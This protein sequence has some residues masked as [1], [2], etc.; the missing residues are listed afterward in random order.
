MIRSCSKGDSSQFELWAEW[1]TVLVCP[2]QR[3]F[4]G[5]G[6]ISAKPRTVWLLTRAVEWVKKFMSLPLPAL[7]SLFPHPGLSSPPVS[8]VNLG[9]CLLWI[10][11]PSEPRA[12]EP[13]LNG[14]SFF[15]I[16]VLLRCSSHVTKFTLLKFTRCGVLWHSLRVMQPSPSFFR[17]WVFVC[18]LVLFLFF[19][20]CFADW[21]ISMN[22]HL[23]ILL[24]PL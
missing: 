21:I 17:F 1:S 3:G 10:S 5:C 22:F 13:P 16:A 6:T 18:F 14:A 15:Q 20:F 9:G 4:S 24:L 23:L 12:P 11:S 8:E 2:R 7:G 19:H